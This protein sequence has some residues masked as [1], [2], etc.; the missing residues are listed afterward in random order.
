MKKI[1]KQLIFMLISL[2]LSCSALFAQGN[3][4]TVPDDVQTIQGAINQAV[5]GDTV[6]VKPGTYSENINFSSKR[7]VVASKFLTTR[8]T[9]YI[10][11]TIINGGGNGSVVYFS[12][13]G[14]SG[15][16]FS[17]FTIKKGK[18]NY[19]G[20]I[21]IKGCNPVLNNLIVEEN[22]GFLRGGGIYIYRS[23]CSLNNITVRNNT[24]RTG[25]GIEIYYHASPEINNVR[26]YNNRASFFGGGIVVFDSSNPVIRNAEVINNQAPGYGYG[27]DVN[28][29]CHVKLINITLCNNVRSVPNRYINPAGLVVYEADADIIN[30]IIR[31]NE[32][33][34]L[35]CV[36]KAS[37]KTEINVKYS[38]IDLNKISYDNY[39]RLTFTG[40]NVLFD[41]A[42]TKSG[43]FPYSLRS[44][45]PCRDMGIPDTTGLGLPSL[46]FAGN[47]RIREGRV[48]MGAYEWDG[49]TSGFPAVQPS[50]TVDP[51]GFNSSVKFKGQVVFNSYILKDNLSYVGA[52]INGECRGVPLQLMKLQNG[53]PASIWQFTGTAR[54]ET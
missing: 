31:N 36:G 18:S 35:N 9:S 26:I 12:N 1:F 4:I 46:D 48:D 11:S 29:K 3:T 27:I 54:M 23:G 8:D 30:C 28:Y 32:P 7:I 43:A 17:G 51:S 40:N 14:S 50:W 52:F 49:T 47:M 37:K 34:N 15:S 10:S 16:V 22:S 25:G 53:Y 24:A 21:Y 42:F 2:I 13:S 41:P 5:N 44:I 33:D 20:G 19:G 38:N 45:S 39:T 6:L